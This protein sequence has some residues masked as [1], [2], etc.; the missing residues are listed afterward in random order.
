[1]HLTTLD[2]IIRRNLLERGLPI[3]Y[4]TEGLIHGAACLRELTIDTLQ[5]INTVRLAIDEVGSVTLPSDCADVVAVS[6]DN[7]SIFPISQQDY[8]SPLRVHNAESGEYERQASSFD[9][10]GINMGLVGYFN[11]TGFTWFWNTNDYGESTGRRFGSRGGT[12]FGYKIIRE[13]KRIQMSAGFEDCGIVLMYI[14]DG[15]SIDAA[16]QI[17]IK[18]QMC[19]QNYINWKSNPISATI[20]TSPEARTFY[21]SKRNLKARI[22][23]LTVTD[24]K[25]ILRKNYT[26]S[27]KN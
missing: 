8:I 2:I 17:D 4:Y 7:G 27:I 15:Q 14:S 12:N 25:N 1:M 5:V 6:L 16:S 21:S 18:A 3:H 22:N 23:S 10:N 13:Q 11:S 19:I 24:I 9:D 20:D 26:A